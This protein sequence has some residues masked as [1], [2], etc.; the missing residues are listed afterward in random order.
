MK[1]PVAHSFIAVTFTWNMRLYSD[2]G[3]GL[4]QSDPTKFD[5]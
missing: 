3:A 4:L 1:H 2:F 5:M